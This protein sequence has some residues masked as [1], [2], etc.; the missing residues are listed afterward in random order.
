MDLGN[1]MEI[2]V[3]YLLIRGMVCLNRRDR[4]LMVDALVCIG[5]HWI[6]PGVN[7]DLKIS[8]CHDS[9][10]YYTT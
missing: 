6:R 8:S 4:V 2:V 7:H 9:P 3:D 5:T 1:L 10:N